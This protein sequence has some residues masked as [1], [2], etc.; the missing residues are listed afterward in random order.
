MGIDFLRFDRKKP[1]MTETQGQPA[2]PS[3]TV[4]TP[5]A[6]APDAAPVPQE[7]LTTQP[8]QP[9]SDSSARAVDFDRV[10]K[11]AYAAL[12]EQMLAEPSPEPG[13]PAPEPEAEPAAPANETNDDLDPD[14][15]RVPDR[16]RLSGLADGDRALVSAA[17]LAAKAQGISVAEAMSRLT[18]TPAQPAEP[19]EPFAPIIGSPDE[20]TARILTMRQEIK[21]AGNEADT[22]RMAELNIAIDEAR[23]ELA[24]A[25]EAK[26]FAETAQVAAEQETATIISSTRAKVHDLYPQFSDRNSPLARKWDDVA[27][28]LQA[29][30]DPTLNNPR[31]ALIV[32]QMAAAELGIA[33]KASLS[34]QSPSPTSP[35]RPVPLVPGS[36]RS[37][38]PA[39]PTGHLDAR[40]AGVNTADDYERLKEEL[41]VGR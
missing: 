36:A 6:A 8:H 22:V 29:N 27:A 39:N 19:A 12:R 1:P 11:D 3:P 15:G 34:T 7:N 16:I 24:Q 4:S 23:E 10:D 2:E 18:G 20:I 40:I 32:A 5:P 25:K 37:S 38:A 13:T 26:T 33:P 17:V 14:A 21:I 41:L 31:A 28:R 35:A 9:A 30:H